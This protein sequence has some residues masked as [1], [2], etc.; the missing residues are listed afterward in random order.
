MENYENIKKFF[1]RF[2][3][4]VSFQLCNCGDRECVINEMEP[5]RDFTNAIKKG[6]S[7]T[8]CN[9]IN[10]A[11]L[12]T[13][14]F[15]EY[16]TGT[17]FDFADTPSKGKERFNDIHGVISMYKRLK[18][19]SK[20]DNGYVL[21]TSSKKLSWM[22][23]QALNDTDI[24]YY[25]QENNGSIVF[26][27]LNDLYGINNEI[28]C[29]KMLYW[30][31][32]KFIVDSIVSVLVNKSRYDIT[33]VSVGSTKISSDYDITLFGDHKGVS[34]VISNFDNI[35]KSIFNELPEIIFDT[36]LYG[37]SFIA[38]DT[39]KKQDR[40]ELPPLPKSPTFF[41]K[42]SFPLYS[43]SKRCQDKF[44]HVLGKSQA[45]ASSQHIWAMTKVIYQMALI[46]NSIYRN[47]IEKE[48]LDNKNPIIAKAW[49]LYEKLTSSSNRRTYANLIFSFLKFK[50]VV[51]RNGTIGIDELTLYNT[52]I[53]FVNFFG[54]ETYFTRGAFLDVVVNQ[55]MCQDASFVK[56]DNNEYIDSALENV[57]ELFTHF[58]KDKYTKRVKNAIQKLNLPSI[59]N[60]V[61][62]IQQ[63][64]DN[65]M[66]DCQ[67]YLIFIKV[68]KIIL[69]L[70]DNIKIDMN[71]TVVIENIID[72]NHYLFDTIDIN[73]EEDKIDE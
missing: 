67:E 5:F 34:K 41:D 58:R 61:D 44:I 51:G 43:M 47:L 9:F 46:N 53:S 30:Y 6:N 13:I 49:N 36:N 73:L 68:L 31:F 59:L 15:R 66:V 17:L 18:L 60:T 7:N 20:L 57:S 33:G 62:E 4:F 71:D 52:F 3:E 25:K 48:F 56:L 42:N 39:V 45:T 29:L 23:I 27:V 10:K 63:L 70:L 22:N 12:S 1:R 8:K 35:I 40:F 64:Q 69:N 16:K 37:V 50:D 26:K 55:Q 14:S 65:C 11:K 21:C 32:R 54:N 24:F 72:N 28:L 19:I 2:I 38:L